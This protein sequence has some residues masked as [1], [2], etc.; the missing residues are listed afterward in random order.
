MNNRDDEKCLNIERSEINHC[1][2][3]AKIVRNK[4]DKMLDMKV[5]MLSAGES[6]R[7]VLAQALASVISRSRLLQLQRIGYVPLITLVR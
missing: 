3:D 7:V 5:G 1:T 2:R 4:L 6:Q